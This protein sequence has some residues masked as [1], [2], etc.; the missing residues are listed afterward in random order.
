M[1]F[2]KK[3]SKKYINKNLKG[4]ITINYIFK[5]YYIYLLYLSIILY[6]IYYITFTLIFTFIIYIF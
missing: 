1:E 5:N 2:W 4:K 3:L 6:I